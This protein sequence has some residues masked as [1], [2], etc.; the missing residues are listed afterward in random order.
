MTVLVKVIQ[1]IQ[2][3]HVS[4]DFCTGDVAIN[5]TDIGVDGFNSPVLIDNVANTNFTYRAIIKITI[6]V[7]KIFTTAKQQIKFPFVINFY[8]CLCQAG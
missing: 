6:A 2:S 4:I 8:V 7:G 1:R 3:I 5:T